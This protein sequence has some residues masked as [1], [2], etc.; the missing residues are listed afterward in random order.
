M[1]K[2]EGVV[3]AHTTPF[4]NDGKLDH[5]VLE[6]Q[7]DFLASNG[8][9]GIFACG[10]TAEAQI[11]TAEERKEVLQSIID[12]N[13]GRMVIVAQCGTTNLADTKDLIDHARTVGCDGVAVVTPY[14][15]VYSQDE[16]LD[17]YSTLAQECDENFPL[18]LYNIPSLAKNNLD[19]STVRTLSEAYPQIAGIKDSS[20][21]MTTFSG[22]ILETPAEF[23]VLVGCDRGF[24]S[25]LLLGGHGSVTG[26]G[27]IFPEPFVNVWN[28]F[29]QGN[30]DE[31]RREQK[32]LIAISAAM[33][34]GAD[35]AMLKAALSLRGIGNGLMRPPF[36]SL[37]KDAV[38]TLKTRL[39]KALEHTGYTL[40]GYIA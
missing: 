4:G 1:R 16:L 8:V 26:P 20:G 29:Q 39:E 28:A 32:K 11:L 9:H 36:K 38:T 12:I 13:K 6:Q 19:V 22:Y 34:E 2:L 23:R 25:V 7:V 5:K 33:G 30:F 18:Y 40:K 27:G 35:F 3:V 10:T 31:A 15:Y 17:Y 14:Y 24:L 21:D 37:V